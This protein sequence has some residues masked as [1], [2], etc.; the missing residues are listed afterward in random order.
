MPEEQH[1]PAAGPA[2]CARGSWGL[3]P[4]PPDLSPWATLWPA[5]RCVPCPVLLL[6]P[7]GLLGGQCWGSRN[8][9]L[10]WH[11]WGF[12]GA[13]SCRP[14]WPHPR[15]HR[16]SPLLPTAHGGCWLLALSPS[17]H[18]SAAPKKQGDAG[19]PRTDHRSRTTAEHPCLPGPAMG[20]GGYGIRCGRWG[21]RA[22]LA[23]RRLTVSGGFP[24]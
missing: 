10:P 6:C 17:G 13:L 9:W 22:G 21:P 8:E 11:W 14:W 2:L 7:G 23:P 24:Y 20:A 1:C 19:P 4:G 12:L 5:L 15:L 3:C 18:C 16:L